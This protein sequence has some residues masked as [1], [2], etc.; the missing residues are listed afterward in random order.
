MLFGM[1]TELAFAAWRRADGAPAADLDLLAEL[2]L[3]AAERL[4][5]LP[6]GVG[7]GLYL[8]NG[9]RFY[10]DAGDHPEICTPECQSPA[11]VVRWQLACERILADLVA[12]LE[13]RHPETRV[14]LFR[15]NVD[16]SGNGATWGCHESYQHRRTHAEMAPHLIPHL[17]TRL[18]YTGAGGFDNKSETLEFMLS[19]RVPQL[20][21]EVGT[22]TPERGIYN[23]RDEPLSQGGFNRLHVICGESLCSELSNYLKIGATALVVRLV[24]AGV[25]TGSTLALRDSVKAMRLI[26][27][28]TSVCARVEL[29]DGRQLGALEIQGEYLAMVEAQLG[30]DFLPAWA[31]ELCRRWRAVLEQLATRPESLATS[32]D[33][34]IKRALFQDRIERGG[35]RAA[36]LLRGGGLG[37]E[38][39]EIDVRFGE[40][41]PHGL[42]HALDD[43]GALTHRIPERGSV[44]DAMQE[45]PPGARAEVRGRAIR[46]L[47]P[48]RTR[49][50]CR[51]DEIRDVVADRS[52]D[53]SDP[54]ATAASWQQLPPAPPRPIR[55]VA[56]QRIGRG[57]AA[58]NGN[59][60]QRATRELDQAVRAAHRAGDAEEAAL[61]RFWSASA[62]Q[63]AGRLDAAEVMLAPALARADE[64][65]AAMR[66]RLWTRHVLL[67][68]ERPA[69]LAEIERALESARE[70]WRRSGG[71]MGRSRVTLCEAR[72]LGARG[73]TAD[74]I[75]YAEQAL[76]EAAGDP[77]AFCITSHLRWQIVFL[78]RGKRFGRAVAQLDLLRART[79]ENALYAVVASNLSLR[80]GRHREALERARSALDRSV[81]FRRHRTRLSAGLAYLEAA[82]ACRTFEGTR[83]VL[84]ELRRWDAAETGELRLEMLRARALVRL[85]RGLNAG[86]ACRAAQ[87]E[88]ERLDTL[89]GCERHA[90]ETKERLPPDLLMPPADRLAGSAQ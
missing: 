9:A 33:W 21:R 29:A 8:A 12:E 56:D 47:H 27:S 62:H 64:V 65:S 15:C 84:Q 17:V 52:L 90:Q 25:C 49:Y 89:L 71:R 30:A 48:E 10:L 22:D 34:A 69:Q 44:E 13:K 11:E 67:R 60:M 45:P 36:A 16:Y 40:L 79:N 24:D 1:E 43:A 26:A 7:V 63:E 42:F 19:P 14:A 59:D 86:E 20:V 3:L 68:I 37:A 4:V 6:E 70:A 35:E 80:L 5:S 77:I 81:H 58:Y 54:F 76:A 88:A 74:A 38:L 32:L 73:R 55:S 61:A 31:S 66:I 53:L 46:E 72:L 18:V 85:A 39:C 57:I 50:R 78:L 2:Y 51:W 82:A 28:D 87:V 83:P 41:S 23:L 75:L